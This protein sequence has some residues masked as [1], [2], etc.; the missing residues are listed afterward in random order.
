MSNVGQGQEGRTFKSEMD[1]ISEME[2]SICFDDNID[3]FLK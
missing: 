3:G 2:M 1:Y